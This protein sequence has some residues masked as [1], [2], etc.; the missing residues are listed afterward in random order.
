MS[1]G[2]IILLNGTSSSGKTAIAH[3]LQEILPGYYLHTGI[4]HYLDGVAPQFNEISDGLNPATAPGLLWVVSSPNR[5]TEIRVGPIALKMFAGMYRACSALAAEGN[6]LIVDDVIFDPRVL[7]AAVSA[8]AASRAFFVGI[9]CPLEIAERREQER[10][11]RNL[12]L[13]RAHYDLVHKHGVYDL[14]IDTSLASPGEA[15]QQ[16]KTWLESGCEPMAFRKLAGR[17]TEPDS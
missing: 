14:E 5:V 13:V 15:A 2:T 11:D 7:E 10:G 4:D 3:V 8:L 9:R 17:S 6:N 1:A 12:G 16:I